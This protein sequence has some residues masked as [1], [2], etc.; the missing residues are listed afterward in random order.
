MLSPTG[1][2]QP[3]NRGSILHGNFKHPPKERYIKLYKW[4]IESWKIIVTGALAIG[5]GLL[6]TSKPENKHESC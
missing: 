3:L 6:L 2:R 4:K 5:T 1:V